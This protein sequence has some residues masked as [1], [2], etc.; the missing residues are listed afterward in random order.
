MGVFIIGAAILLLATW[1]FSQIWKFTLKFF[2][3][4]LLGVVGLVSSLVVAVRRT[5]KVCYILWYKV[6]EKYFRKETPREGGYEVDE[7]DVPP[8]LMEEFNSHEEVI[9]KKNPIQT[10]EF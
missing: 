6:K 8:Q 2:Y 9:V 5:G 10:N 3:Y 4:F 7:E 1:I